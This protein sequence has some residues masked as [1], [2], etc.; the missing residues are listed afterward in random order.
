MKTPEKLET[1]RLVLRR[2]RPDD[3]PAVLE[4]Y[5]GDP[6]V[7]RFMGWPRHKSLVDT[8]AF[9][10]FSDTS[11]EHW[12]AGPYL[13]LTRDGALLGS[14]GLEFE[15]PYRAMTGYVLARDA[16]GRGYATEALKTVADLAFRVGVVRLYAVCHTE[17]HASRRV[18]EK[19][20]FEREGVLRRY[21]VFPN[22]APGVPADVLCYAR[23]SARN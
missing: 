21:L 3:A 20:G 2:P 14:T 1:A 6:E 22:L 12:Q 8:K 19:C 9:L 18:L 17:H 13:I 11:W 7:T 23:I 4:R 15:T 16:W 5:A 10:A